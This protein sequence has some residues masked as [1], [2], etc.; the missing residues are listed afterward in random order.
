MATPEKKVHNTGSDAMTALADICAR[1]PAIKP[2]DIELFA[3]V[4]YPIAMVELRLAEQTFEDFEIVQ[5]TV[6]RMIALGLRDASIIGKTLGLSTSYVQKVIR[7]LQGYGHLDR[8]GLTQLGAE[9]LK[10]QQKI[11]INETVQTFQM[12]ALNGTLLK[13]EQVVAENSLSELAD[14]HFLMGHLSHL[15]GISE[16]TLRDQLMG[17]GGNAFIHRDKGILHANVTGIRDARCA[18]L[19]YARAYMLKLAGQSLPIVLTKRYNK[20]QKELSK[21]FTWQPFSVGN[22]G[23]AGL[24]G[25]DPGTVVGS[26]H[27][28]EYLL[29]LLEMLIQ[30]Q[31]EHPVKP[32]EVL[33]AAGKVCRLHTEHLRTYERDRRIC[34]EIPDQAL[35][36]VNGRLLRLLVK[37][38]QQGE[39][40]LTNE[41][42]YGRLISLRVSGNTLRLLSQKL[43]AMDEDTLKKTTKKLLDQFQGYEGNA[44]LPD[45]MLAFIND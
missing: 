18:G 43:G 1:Y 42:L 9:S 20:A 45:A 23:I 37:C 32:E 14:T 19:Q 39:Q 29:Q 5:L 3:P 44:L 38:Y 4:Y 6:L 21:R 22:P 2:C 15:E 35:A 40:L 25:F 27:A 31:K 24:L 36:A 41:Y 16:Q 33:R 13:V 30:A 10:Q 11:V 28:N 8:N 34:V 26:L 7:L 17:Q 12:D